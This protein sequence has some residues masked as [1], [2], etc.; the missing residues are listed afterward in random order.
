MTAADHLAALRYARACYARVR[1][2]IVGDHSVRT[3]EILEALDGEIA[4]RDPADVR[5]PPTVGDRVLICGAEA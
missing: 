4:A 3:Q 1:V 5:P 2:L